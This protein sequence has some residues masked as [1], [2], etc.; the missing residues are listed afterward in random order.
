MRYCHDKEINRLVSVLVRDGWNF[1]R[2]RHGKLRKPD[3]SGF[4]TIP[5]TPSD[6]RALLNLRRDIRRQLRA[7]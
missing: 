5:N 2:G 1:T 7:S 3:G 6:H 4:V